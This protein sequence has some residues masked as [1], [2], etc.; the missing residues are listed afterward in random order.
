MAPKNRR[1]SGGRY[2]VDM[3]FDDS[4]E[5]CRGKLSRAVL[6]KG[7]SF[8][9]EVI[10]LLSRSCLTVT[11]LP[12]SCRSLFCGNSKGAVDLE[13]C[14][15][16]LSILDRLKTMATSFATQSLDY[17]TVPLRTT[18]RNK[19]V[20]SDSSMSLCGF[21]KI[22]KRRIKASGRQRKR[23]NRRRHICGG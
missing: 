21:Q 13:G 22:I 4:F 15:L 7:L 8:S 11:K 2:T 5:G 23:L 10:M 12:L 18:F 20:A 14:S 16:T 9:G 6:N 17:S 19:G 1:G 3:V